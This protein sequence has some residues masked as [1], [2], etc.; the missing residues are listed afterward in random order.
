[1]SSTIVH[2][3]RHGEVFNPTKILYGRIPG[4]HLSER[5]ER[6]ARATA[7]SF[8]GH[9]VTYLAASPLQ[10]AQET[11][12]PIVAVTRL[13]LHTDDDLLEAGNSFEG[14]RIKGI[15]SQL[16]DP[17]L[18][19]RLRDPRIPSWGEPYTE[20]RDRMYDA[21]FRAFEAAKGHEAIL[22]SHQLP[23]VTIQRDVQ[24]L[25]LFHNPA[26]RQCELASVT[27]LVF[28]NDSGVITD[29]VY[30]EPAAAVK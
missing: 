28:N 14:Y 29:M 7:E 11:A 2:L 24:Q 5:G 22:V 10:R 20:I 26:A 6:M 18:W 25:P 12:A 15:R 3:V 17:R 4:Y 13:P 23:I 21:I 16:W 9:D 8:I 1:M 30:T 27:S 19:P